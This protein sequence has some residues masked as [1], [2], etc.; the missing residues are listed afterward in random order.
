MSAEMKDLIQEVISKWPSP[1]RPLAG[2]DLGSAERARDFGGAADPSGALRR[3]IRRLMRRAAE[4]GPAEVRRRTVRNTAIEASTFLPDW[5]DRS[6]EAREAVLGDAILYRATLAARRPMPRDNR[7]VFAYFDVSGSV[8]DEVPSVAAAL[9]PWCRRGLCRIHVFSTAV[10]PASVRDLAAR[11]FSSTGGTDIDCVLEHALSLPRARRP[12]SIVILT[13]GYTGRPHP[14]LAARFRA[15]GIRLYV[16][17][18]GGVAGNSQTA[19]L[20]SLATQLDNLT[21]THCDPR[22]ATI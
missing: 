7:R 6:H 20:S 9:E 22:P 15:S 2:R 12:R 5:K 10:A 16:G 13:D 8:A 1:D 17:L 18:F 21:F 4:P 11:R 19:D 3:G 14:S